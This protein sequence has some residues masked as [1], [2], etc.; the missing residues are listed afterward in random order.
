MQ[1][2]I[3]IAS[4][5]FLIGGTV[6]LA[7]AP[8]ESLPVIELPTG[9]YYV[10][11][12]KKGDSL[13]GIARSFSWNDSILTRLNPDAV[14]PLTKGYKVF[15]PVSSNPEQKDDVSKD[16]KPSYPGGIY[17]ATSDESLGDI[18]AAYKVSVAE[19][20]KLNAGIN[21]SVIKQ[22]TE[23]LL[24]PSGTGLLTEYVK[25]PSFRLEA[26]RS[27][28]P[29]KG[30]DWKALGRRI[31]VNPDLLKKANPAMGKPKQRVVLP[32]IRV[33]SI[34]KEVQSSDPSE[35]SKAGIEEIYREVHSLNGLS[36]GS[37]P[38]RFAVVPS[39]RLSRMDLEFIRGFLS[40]VNEWNKEK[41]SGLR[42]EIKVVD[43]SKGE[44]NVLSQLEDYE[45]SIILISDDEKIPGFLDR[46]SKSTQTPLVN[47]LDVKSS[48]YEANP[49]ILQMLAPSQVFNES[50]ASYI[51]EKWKGRKLV[52]AGKPD[53]NDQ[54]A[55]SLLR[56]WP[57][58]D[59]VNLDL[60][61]L[62]PDSFQ[63]GNSY[64]IY[65]YPVKRAEVADLLNAVKQI[66]EE[67]PLMELDILGRPNLILNEE[68]MKNAFH[69][70][71]LWIPSRF[72]VE[73]ES[74]A[75]QRFI[76]SF[77]EVYERDPLKSV[78]LYA[79][80]GYDL[81]NYLI[82]QLSYA[83]GDVNAFR[84]SATGLQ[85]AYNFKRE[86]PWSG[87]VNVPVFMVNFTPWDKVVRYV[88]EK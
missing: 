10:Y 51:Y 27:A 43:T 59:V 24:P 14:S 28:T 7:A 6:S 62:S 39:E 16:G 48:N 33:D 56:L 69:A 57:Q 82:T 32:L 19:I 42:M 13:F 26:F 70:V 12:A 88:V 41:T 86:K 1:L 21:K 79:A 85:A 71:N 65:G 40:A 52:M 29:I 75:Y 18:S 60:M 25:K 34:M 47:S 38:Y 23:L 2:H 76:K 30:E 61:S 35:S 64:L 31:G 74:E 80:T 87:V 45:P 58:K 73:R 55:Q 11:S 77:K 63:D 68:S 72:Y 15:Y 46:F 66:R 3:N 36:D 8:T 67:N 50:I 37:V 83:H 5:A 4:L 81:G 20:L 9:N 54:L 53:S 49:Y 22:G 84:P 17:T 78:P 44:A